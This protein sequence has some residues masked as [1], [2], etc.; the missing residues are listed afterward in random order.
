MNRSVNKFAIIA[1]LVFFVQSAFGQVYQFKEFNV[2]EGLSHPFVYTVAED[3]NGFIW[4]GTGEG[5][6]RFDGFE[7]V[8]SEMDDSLTNGFVTSSYLDVNGILWF[9]H[10]SGQITTYDGSEFKLL[11]TSDDVKSSIVGITGDG[12]GNVFIAS[13]N[14]GLLKVNKDFIVEVFIDD[15]SGDLI[16]AL[17]FAGNNN[18]LIGTSDGLSLYKYKD[19]SFIKEYTIKELEYITVQSIKTGKKDNTFWIGTEDS[20]F[21]LIKGKGEAF[22]SYEITNFGEKYELA[23]E[24][25]Q[26]V[27]EDNDNILWVSTFGKGILKFIPDGKQEY[28]YLE[29]VHY[30]TENGLS[31]NFIKT[32]FQD[33]EGNFWIGTYGNGLSFSIDE[34]LTIQYQDIDALNGDVLSVAETDSYLWLGGNKVIAKIDKSNNEYQIIGSA[35]GLPKDKI[36]AMYA[37]ANQKLWIGTEKSGIYKLD[38]KTNKV[39]SFYQSNNS[40]GNSINHITGT[41]DKVWVSTQNGVLVFD[42]KLGS[43]KLYNTAQGLPHNNIK[44]VFIDSDKNP[45]VATRGHG[46]F[47]LNSELNYSIEG[48]VNIVFTSITEDVNGN[49]WAVTYGDGVFKFEQDSITHFSTDNGLKSNYCYTA[50]SD[51]V[52]KVWVGHGLGMSSIDINTGEVKIISTEKGIKGDC[53]YNATIKQKDGVILTGTTDGLVVYDRSKEKES[54]FPPRLNITQLLFSDIKVDYSKPV[55][56]PYDI[57]KLNIGFVGLSYSDPVGVSYQY[58]LDGYDLEWSDVNENR[59]ALY[60]RVEDGNYTFI[61]KACN[62]EGFCVEEPFEIKISV[63]PPFWK[64]WWF[65]TIAILTGLGIVYSYIKYR[66]KKQKEMQEYLENELQKRTKEVYAQ[67][68]E[69]EIKNRDIT[70]SINYA[71]RIQQSILPSVKTIDDNFSGAFVYYQPRD[72]VSGDFYWYEKVNDDKFLIVCADST[73]HGVPGAFMSMIGTTLIKDICLRKEIN[74]PSEVLDNLDKELQRTLNQN[75]DAERAHDG[76]DII[77]CEI[78]VKTHYMR[79]SSAMRPL[80]LYK[81]KELQYVKGTKAS[82]GGDPKADKRFENIGFQLHQGDII[83]MFSDGYPDQFGGPR[84]KK[85]K[86]DRVKNMLAD[87][88]SKPM[89]DQHE[90]VGSTFNDWRGKLQQVDD[91]LFMG[92]RI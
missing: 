8:V 28:S 68:E 85:F 54:I 39:R 80:I 79:F 23:Y 72:I 32:V 82:I 38:V 19:D 43:S 84:G 41:N 44:S 81:D 22:D 59:T 56:L 64:T 73:G 51:N 87:V 36:V 35:K 86:L 92:V 2:E 17:Q 58:M 15:F 33:W 71:Q 49:F 3:N 42:L 40:M 18:F 75:I 89:E 74:S 48:N 11:E 6:C 27:L 53:N 90:F 77:V 67:K 52:D 20:G 76:M 34:A 25:V 61:L 45:W 13:Q 46:I 7:F 55:V 91:V 31:N 62:S 29:L 78:D 83:Y 60:P 70:D 12:N 47:V 88:C 16:Y 37:D 26:S 66:E 9:G 50:I 4:I 69:L 1:L 5:L 24:N 14:S 30:S 10:N 21:Y 57:Y 65:I 63:R